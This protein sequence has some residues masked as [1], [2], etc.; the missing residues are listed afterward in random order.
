MLT[1]PLDT[2]FNSVMVYDIVSTS[3]CLCLRWLSPSSADIWSVGCSVCWFSPISV[4]CI[5]IE[6]ATGKPPW[7]QQ[8][9]EVAALFYIGTTKSHPPIPEHLLLETKDFLLKCLQDEP[10]LRPSASEL[11]QHPFV[12]GE[13][14]D[15]HPIF[16]SS[17]L[18][19]EH[20][21]HKVPSSGSELEN[22]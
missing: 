10:S 6:M 16:C 3:S 18:V 22:L 8:Y 4:G 15:P 11:L 5:V 7:T 12:T 17:S 20:S 13:Y 14:K 19:S 21:A 2:C 9:K 1:D